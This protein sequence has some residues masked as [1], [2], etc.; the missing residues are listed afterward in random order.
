MRDY[1]LRNLSHTRGR[2]GWQNITTGQTQ[3]SCNLKVR[4]KLAAQTTGSSAKVRQQWPRRE[5]TPPK[6]RDEFPRDDDVFRGRRC[7]MDNEDSASRDGRARRYRI[8][9]GKLRD[10]AVADALALVHIWSSVRRW[11]S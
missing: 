1:G 4:T 6:P 10:G 11:P 8:R 7:G 9:E 2:A 3:R 5:E